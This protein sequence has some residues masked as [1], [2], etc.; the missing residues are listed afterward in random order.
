MKLKQSLLLIITTFVLLVST[1]SHAGRQGINFYYGAGAGAA[2]PEASDPAPIGEIMF[3]AEEDGWALEIIGYTS[4]ETG[5]DNNAVDYSIS[6]RHFG[7]AYRT[8]ER[9][10]NWFKFKVSSTTMDFDNS[11]TPIDYETKG[12]S[13]TF[14]W[15][16]RINREARLEIDYNFYN[17]DNLNDP[18]HIVSARYFWGGSEYQG[19][20][21]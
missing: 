3:G 13:Y 19:R 5:T 20:D 2:L 10:N 14:G 11:N 8:I 1:N 16:I 7:I 15:G 6:G 17:S 21:F 4:T 9:H 18:V 12:T